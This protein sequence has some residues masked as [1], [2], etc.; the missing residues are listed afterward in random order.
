MGKERS[1][2]LLERDSVITLLKSTL[3][4]ARKG[5]LSV[6]FVVG[7]AGMGKTTLLDR[8][9]HSVRG[10]EVGQAR[11]ET[12]EA[13][14]SFGFLSQLLKSLKASDLLDDIPELS[15]NERAA[16]VWWRLKNWAGINRTKPLL[17]VLDDI[18]WADPDSLMM[19]ALL[20]RNLNDAKIALIATMR[21]WPSK[22]YEMGEELVNAAKARTARLMPLSSD[23]S[24][25]LVTRISGK[26]VDKQFTLQLDNLCSGNPMLLTQLAEYL[27]ANQ[28]FEQ[29]DP[30][31]LPI[32]R[33]FLNRFIG[34]D[35]N[36]LE[37][38]Q[39]ASVYGVQ[40]RPSVVGEILGLNTSGTHRAINALQTGGV[41]RSVDKEYAVFTHSLIRQAIYDDIPPPVASQMHGAIFRL[42]WEQGV[43][44][45]EAATHAIHASS[46]GDQI[47]IEAITEAGFDALRHG[48]LNTA[49]DWFRSAVSLIGSR[50]DPKLQFRLAE[51][52]LDAGAHPDAVMLCRTLIEHLGNFESLSVKPLL[53]DVYQLLGR[54]LFRTNETIQAEEAMR[55]VAQLSSSKD[56]TPGIEALL[57]ASLLAM[58]TS[59]PRRSLELANEAHC[60]LDSSSDP[61]L[62]TWIELSQGLACATM[63][64]MDDIEGFREKLAKLSDS[65]IGIT[66]LH[67]VTAWGPLL[68]RLQTEKFY[69]HFSESLKIY[70][71]VIAD[72]DSSRLPVALGVYG[73]AHADTLSRL[74]RLSESLEVLT[75]TLNDGVLQAGP[76]SWATVGLA[77]IHYEFGDPQ[78]SAAY[79]SQ[80][81]AVIGSKSDSFPLLRCW[82]L[83]I[84][85]MLALDENNIELACAIA[86]QVE[87]ISIRAGLL[88]PCAAPWYPAALMA[89]LAAG[90]LSDVE[91]VIEYLETASSMLPCRYPRALASR[92]RALLLDAKGDIPKAQGYFEEA[93][94]Y[95]RQLPMPLE[96]AETLL[97]YGAFLRRNHEPTTAR[98]LLNRAADIA[99]GCG[100]RRLESL[101]ITELHAALGRRRRGRSSGPNIQ[102]FEGLTPIQQRVA[103]LA[104]DGLTNV[105]IGRRLFL[106]P[107]TIEHHLSN[108]YVNMNISSRRELKGKLPARLN[109]AGTLN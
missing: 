46:F 22:A 28:E 57:E 35:A 65:P 90:R 73:V 25:A 8:L 7:E 66:A 56:R 61:R 104:A 33:L 91:R 36:T 47:A 85:S 86:A 98:E 15:L 26:V 11:G 108:I 21:P 75:A 10:F 4:T 42:L 44:P 87:D 80:I 68:I 48:A 67:N 81:E 49:A 24:V 97:A 54:S 59:G 14:L 64:C 101:A 96:E 69:E 102:G 84:R 93:L 38:A 13:T 41:L 9:V 70:E 83:R 107:R 51:G 43:S 19:I 2:A 95:H 60:L 100:A 27:S 79:L 94:T 63:C 34:M 17:L 62:V 31:A 37:Y 20:I 89:Y 99:A 71:M 109:H 58:Y 55:K 50:T 39:V 1:Q 72:T 29:L 40:F 82:L 16:T 12:L 105:E 23:A 103:K 78:R 77:H 32:P 52:L 18:H 5:K 30:A 3:T 106:S 45:G 88:E 6:A 53:R 76:V 92:G 74:G